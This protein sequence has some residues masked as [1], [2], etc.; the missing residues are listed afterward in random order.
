MCDTLFRMAQ[1][2]DD[3]VMQTIALC[4]KL[5][6]YF[7]QSHASEDTIRTWVHRVQE[8]AKQH[9]EPM[10][11][12]FVWSGR[13]I[14]YYVRSG[15]YDM[16]IY[17][18][19]SMLSEAEAEQ[20]KVG[21]A[22]CYSALANI[23]VTKQR[24]E[25]AIDYVMKEIELFESSNDTLPRYNISARYVYA[26]SYLL[27]EKGDTVRSADYLRKAVQYAQNQSMLVYA[28]IHYV[29]LYVV[30]KKF[31]RAK[32]VLDKYR[33]MYEQNEELASEKRDFYAMEAYYYRAIEQ[34]REALASVDRWMKS[35]E[36]MGEIAT[37]P[38]LNYEADIY[39]DMER[40][41][42]A[43][44][45]YRE[46]VG[47]E[48]K[49]NDQDFEQEAGRLSILLQQNS[50]REEMYEL[51]YRNRT[52]KIR[53]LWIEAGVLIL[54][55]IAFAYM[56]VKQ[57]QLGR[58]MRQS[59]RLLIEKNRILELSK[60]DLM[61]MKEIAE[62]SS[63]MKTSFIQQMSH[64]IRTPLNAIVGFSA[65]LASM[66]HTDERISKASTEIATSS[67][68]MLRMVDRRLKTGYDNE[69]SPVD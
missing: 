9:N 10:Y 51:E 27:E 37:L 3:S 25:M 58:T 67:D 69:Q 13:L 15:Q 41:D 56:S 4:T 23:Y 43:A 28:S 33:P 59:R 52:N 32:E 66:Q 64:E 36:N 30:E 2:W 35:V 1:D 14:P 18:A 17:E 53:N 16:A 45:V 46:V 7:V 8:F 65:V 24:P 29:T 26:A 60:Q 42:R 50:L 34:Y 31:A 44:E 61:R 63:S 22:D 47:I 62:Q 39:W 6:H 68:E 40:K 38:A 57:I 49:M 11:Y 5:D 21:I 19:I 54:I 48:T 12:Y 20:Y 55:V